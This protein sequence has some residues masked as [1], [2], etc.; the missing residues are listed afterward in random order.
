MGIKYKVNEKF[1]EKWCPE[2]AYVLGYIY[3]DGSLENSPYLRGKYLRVTSTDRI[4]IER[5]KRW[6][7]SEHTIVTERPKI[8]TRK[9]RYML[10]IGSHSLYD[11]LEALGLYPHKSLTIRFPE[12]PRKWLPHFVRGYFDGDGCAFLEMGKGKTQQ[13]IIKR[14]SVIFTSGSFEY[15]VGLCSTLRKAMGLERSM[16]YTSQRSFQLRCATSDAVRLFTFMYGNCPDSC[17]LERKFD[18]FRTY[19]G[20]RPERVDEAVN[21][22][23]KNNGGMAKG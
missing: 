3:A 16:V 2:M 20:L 15:L 17:F 4:T 1:F 6:L 19:F 13:K 21:A 7:D 8:R 18:I 9:T 22:I 10:R 12:L 23:L 11:S 5:I 14:L